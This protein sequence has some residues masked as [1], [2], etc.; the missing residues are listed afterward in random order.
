MEL[1]TNL[2]LFSMGINII[3]IFIN[4]LTTYYSRK[5]IKKNN[6]RINSINSNIILNILKT[7]INKVSNNE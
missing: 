1:K 4:I 7:T 6:K 2:E 5:N 3:L